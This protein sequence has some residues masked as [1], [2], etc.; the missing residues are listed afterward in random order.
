M[1]W[2]SSSLRSSS[3]SLSSWLRFAEALSSI[4][5]LRSLSTLSSSVATLRLVPVDRRFRPAVLWMRPPLICH[6]SDQAPRSRVA[7]PGRSFSL[8]SSVRPRRSCRHRRCCLAG[9]PRGHRCLVYIFINGRKL[10]SVR[11][12]FDNRQL[13]AQLRDKRRSR[14]ILSL[15][16]FT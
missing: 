6:Q 5:S 11:H 12:P 1:P 9:S 14:G 10:Q 13:S 2:V 3:S 15:V 8:D 7:S 4:K 16:P